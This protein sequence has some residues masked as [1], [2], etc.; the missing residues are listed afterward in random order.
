MHKML[1][2]VVATD[3]FVAHCVCLSATRPRPAKAAERINV[4]FEVE[5]LMGAQGTL[6]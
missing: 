2:L 1:L 5:T 3:D 6:C 4:L